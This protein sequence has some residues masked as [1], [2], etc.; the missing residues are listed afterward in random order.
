MSFDDNDFSDDEFERR[1]EKARNHPLRRQAEEVLKVVGLL[2]EYAGDDEESDRFGTTILESAHIINAKLAGALGSDSYMVCMQNAAIIRSH[3]EYIRLSNHTL[4]EM[5]GIDKKY[6]SV[7][8]S[9]MEKFRELFVEWA[10][11][12]RAM[13]EKDEFSEDE[14]GLF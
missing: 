9:E 14:W 10:K 13:K 11:E 4:K 3:A 5:T 6:I 8:R 7:L 1:R 2:I 12:V